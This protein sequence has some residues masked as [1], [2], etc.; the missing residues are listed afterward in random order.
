METPTDAVLLRI[1]LTEAA[2]WEHKPLYEAI[3]LRAREQGLAGATVLRGPM[4][5]GRSSHLHTAKILDLSM[6]LPVVIEIF[7]NEEKI[8]AFL[9][10][11]DEM[12]TGGH[13]TMEQVRVIHYGGGTDQ[14][15]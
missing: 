3:V 6:N 4:G 2:K 14:H 11:L 12:L 9:P 8:N 7:E 13:V 15:G 10:V 1:Y 5:Y